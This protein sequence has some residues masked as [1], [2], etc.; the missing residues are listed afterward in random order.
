MPML[1]RNYTAHVVRGAALGLPNAIYWVG[2][3]GAEETF[4]EWRFFH[5]I[6]QLDRRVWKS[7]QG[8]KRQRLFPALAATWGLSEH[9]FALPPGS[10]NP[11]LIS[12]FLVSSEALVPFLLELASREQMRADKRAQ[13]ARIAKRLLD[14]A[15]EGLKHFQVEASS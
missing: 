7:V 6:I 14:L 3:D 8:W 9:A 2:V 12:E 15:Q 5:D 10:G 4:W 1:R 13:V 11:E